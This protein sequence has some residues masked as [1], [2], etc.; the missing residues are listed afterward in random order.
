MTGPVDGKLHSESEELLQKN[1]NFDIL[2]V[3]AFPD[4]SI[5]V[6]YLKD[7]EWETEVWV[8]NTP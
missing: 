3:K 5:M 2:Y 7:I 8:A 1:P 6:K 4:R